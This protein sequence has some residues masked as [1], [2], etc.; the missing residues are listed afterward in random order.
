VGGGGGGCRVGGG[1]RRKRHHTWSK[2]IPRLDAEHQ[3]MWHHVHSGVFH[4]CIEQLR[5]IPT[6]LREQLLGKAKLC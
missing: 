4:P 1:M 2:I 6:A 3:V 5:H